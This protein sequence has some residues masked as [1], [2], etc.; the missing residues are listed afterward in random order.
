MRLA[1]ALIPLVLSIVPIAHAEAELNEHLA[2][3]GPYLGKTWSGEMDNST[4]EKPVINVF[5]W[6]SA[7]GGQ[8]VRIVH[9][10]NDGEYGG[11]SMVVWDSEKESLVYF[12]FTTAGF[13]TQGTMNF[14]WNTY[15]AHEFV[16]GEVGDVTEVKSTGSFLEDGRMLDRAEYLKNGEWS[17]A[18]ESYYEETP[19]AKVILP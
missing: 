4:P 19:E 2:A 7:L 9:S 15:T 16:T 14:G 1:L 6:E 10:I 5:R 18:R 12:Y 3:F 8:A 11:E 13:Y 17:V